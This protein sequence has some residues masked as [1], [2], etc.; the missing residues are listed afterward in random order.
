[1]SDD[2]GFVDGISEVQ[3]DGKNEFYN[4]NGMRV[5]TLRKGIYIVNSKKMVVN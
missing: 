1:M 2:G 4:L 3:V 5:N